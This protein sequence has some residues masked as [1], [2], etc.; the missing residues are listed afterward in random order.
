R[1]EF[2]ILLTDIVMP[3][4]DGL[5]LSAKVR[6]DRRLS[7]IPIIAVS[8]FTTEEDIKKAQEAGIDEY[9]SKLKLDMLIDMIEKNLFKPL[10]KVA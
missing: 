9:V 1:Q 4:M 3:R 7:H 8:S 6:Q 10:K 5:E 2:D